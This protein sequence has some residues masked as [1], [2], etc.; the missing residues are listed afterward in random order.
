MTLKCTTRKLLWAPYAYNSYI[1]SDRTG[2]KFKNYIKT[3]LFKPIETLWST[4][5]QPFWPHCERD[6][7]SSAQVRTPAQWWK[8]R[9]LITGPSGNSLIGF[10]LFGFSRCG[11]IIP[12]FFSI[13]ATW[14]PV[15]LQCTCRHW[16]CGGSQPTRFASVLFLLVLDLT[17]W[18]SNIIVNKGTYTGW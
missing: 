15:F 3:K 16:V 18:Q 2:G 9:V 8:L 13:P 12:L 11:N 4:S 5:L 14:T 7:R 17:S 6:L 10:F 1:C